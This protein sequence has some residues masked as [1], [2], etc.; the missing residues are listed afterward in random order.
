LGSQ[1][2]DVDQ[3][4]RLLDDTKHPILIALPLNMDNMSL[5]GIPSVSKN[6]ETF[7]VYGWTNDFLGGGFIVR[8]FRTVNSTTIGHSISY[9]IGNLTNNEERLIC[10]SL[11]NIEA[12]PL[13]RDFEYGYR[14]RSFSIQILP[15]TTV[16]RRI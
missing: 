12:F 3:I 13:V 15:K 4:K 1:G 10:P 7:L 14:R 8:F 6:V 2:Y 11:R 5:K 16:I 9:L